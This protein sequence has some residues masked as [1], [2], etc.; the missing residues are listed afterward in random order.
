V[1][2]L[3]IYRCVSFAT[4]ALSAYTMQSGGR[5]VRLKRMYIL[6]FEHAIGEIISNVVC[7]G[8][9][10]YMDMNECVV[11]CV[12]VVHGSCFAAVYAR[13]ACDWSDY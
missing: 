11:G 7:V 13:T 4:C 2:G 10:C 6:M 9:N 3:Y 12:A 5:D 1:R 8:S